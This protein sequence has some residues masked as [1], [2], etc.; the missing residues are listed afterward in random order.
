MLAE[1]P[2]EEINLGLNKLSNLPIEFG[3]I[4]TLNTV[5]LE[6]N[7]FLVFP[8]CLCQLLVGDNFHV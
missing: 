7:E 4:S 5:W 2:I 6:D 8:N 3:R 1:T